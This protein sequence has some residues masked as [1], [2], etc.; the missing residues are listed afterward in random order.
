MVYLAC[1]LSP[2]TSYLKN[3]DA[4]GILAVPACS[5]VPPLQV[6][7]SECQKGAKTKSKTS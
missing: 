4:A 1:L 2:P 6:N 3:Y 5:A 7:S